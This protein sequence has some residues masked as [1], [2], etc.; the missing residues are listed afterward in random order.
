MPWSQR[1]T[2]VVPVASIGQALKGIGLPVILGILAIA[3]IYFVIRYAW[4]QR[5]P[6]ADPIAGAGVA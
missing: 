3:A 1:V 4:I 2:A 5:H 6:A